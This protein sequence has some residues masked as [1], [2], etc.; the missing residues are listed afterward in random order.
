MKQEVKPYGT[1]K[2]KKEEVA[3][4][5]DNIAP[6]YDLLNHVLSMG[7]DILWR[8]KAVRMLKPFAPK[9][10]IDIATGTGDFA[11]ESLSLNPDKITGV[12]ISSQMLEVG[13]Q[14]MKKRGVDQRIEMVLGDSE[15]LPFETDTFDA[16]TVAFGVRNFQNLEAGLKEM[17]RV[18]KPGAPAAIIEFSTPERFPMKQL[19][20]FYFHNILPTIGKLVSKDARAYTYLPESVNAFPY[21][22]RFVNIM[23]DCGFKEVSATPL[24]FGIASIYF[25]KK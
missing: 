15:N 11:L 16:L 13:R 19:Y 10:I 20:L 1:E 9:K 14:K 18:L 3:N 25:G 17:N 21:G 8:K 7:I 24:T 5:F 4:M 12:D 23:K 22:E 6:K 2:S